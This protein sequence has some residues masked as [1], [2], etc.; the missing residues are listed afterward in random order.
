QLPEQLAA[1]LPT[2]TIRLRM[3]VTSVTP[4]EVRTADG[5]RYA[6]RA[7]VVATDAGGR[8]TLLNPAA[9]AFSGW[10]ADEADGRPVEEVLRLVR[11]DSGE[12]LPA[13]MERVASGPAG[14][15]H[16]GEGGDGRAAPAGE[17]AGPESSADDREAGTLLVGRDGVRR[18]VS[19]GVR[20]VRGP[21]GAVMG[22]VVVVRDRTRDRAALR[23]LEESRQRMELA[24]RG[25]ELGT[26]DWDMRTGTVVFNARWTEMLGYRPEEL[27]A[28]IETWSER[29]HPDDR[30]SV[31]DALDAHLAGR[32][33]SFDTVHRLRHRSGRWVWIQDRGRILER[34]DQGRPVRAAGTHL[35][36]S[37]WKHAIDALQESERRFRRLAENA[38]DLIYRYRLHPD[39]GFEYVSPA[40]TAMTG[41]T[42]EDHYRDPELGLRLA[43]PE[44]RPLLEAVAA[45][46]V[47]PGSP[48]VLRWIHKDGRVIWTEQRNVV[49]EDATGRPVAIEGI[50]RDITGRMEMEAALREREA[51]LRLF[52]EHA[53]AALAMFDREVRYLAASRRWLADY[54]LQGDVTGRSHYEVFPEIGEGWKS[55]HRRALAGEV[56]RAEEDRFERLD[57]RE[58]WVRWEV[59]PWHR[60]GGEVGGIVILSEDITERMEAAR[61]LRESEER[62]R[63]ALRHLPDLVMIL[64]PELRV[65]FANDSARTLLGVNPEE[66]VGRPV[67][68]LFPPT[69]DARRRRALEVA[70]AGEVPSPVEDSAHFPEAGERFL[71][72]QY[73]PLTDPDGAVREILAITRDLTEPVR[74]ERDIRALAE[75]L[76]EKVR[77]RTRQLEEANRELESFSYSVSHDLKAPL[78]AIDGYAALL[79]QEPDLPR[80]AGDLLDEVRAGARHMASLIDNLLALSRVG[81]AELSLASVPLEPL[82]HALLERERELAPERRIDM[83]AGH[84]MPVVAD[85]TLLRQVLGNVLANAVKFTRPRERAIIRVW[86]RRVGRW[87]EVRVRDNGVGFDPAYSEKLFRVFERLHY[88]EEFE[89]TGVGLAIVKRIMERHGGTV[90]MEGAPD[91]G[92]EIRLRFPAEP[93]GADPGVA[94]PE[95]AH[96]G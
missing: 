57:G 82:V 9:E 93:P 50:A 95:G 53:P 32:S 70:R 36:I 12:P 85:A 4:D 1:R 69:A 52:I 84:L 14:E 79:A 16:A 56:L 76:E 89:G 26:W 80:A 51:T 10:S 34:D 77:E 74:A 23:L 21:D 42:P 40:A 64:D 78:R 38:P 61:S 43:H 44:D 25:A 67:A 55:V 91:E 2:G 11:E 24:L 17:E 8:V 46:A 20:P 81:R 30:Q 45:G 41:Y 47:E 37:E 62:F 65:Q 7:V 71:R 59:R 83:E 87:V 92:A 27:D 75:A 58:Q 22:A 29:V 96:V 19:S 49:V 72:T 73:L 6:A 18:P 86:T 39:P 28:S 3:A 5:E 60:E 13:P 31:F 66:A 68:E 54:G 33:E 94:D 15:G 63:E 35:D 48:L 88:P 90:A